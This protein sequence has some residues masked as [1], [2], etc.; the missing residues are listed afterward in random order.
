MKK[1]LFIL[2]IL[3]ILLVSSCG[4]TDKITKEVIR[5]VCPDGSTVIDADECLEE[6][7]I[8]ED[9]QETASGVEQEISIIASRIVD[10]DTFVLNTGEKVRLICVDTPETNEFY[11][12]EATDYLT[13]LILNKEIILVKDVS[14]T[15]RYG[16]LLR[17]VYLGD[18]F[19]N[20]KLVEKGYATVFRYSPDTKLC[21]ELEVLEASAKN[22]KLGIWFEEEQEADTTEGTGY[23]CNYNAYNCGNFRTHAE[24][25]A[26]YEACGGVNND[27]HQLD[28]DKDGIACES[29]P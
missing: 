4:T 3:N 23:I 12:Q 27:V 17:Y 21:D 29:L 13:N 10:G 28:K 8:I 25:Q 11:Y 24:A 9:E 18:I 7:K 1:I 5:Y 19:V 2:F 6:E 14:E 26:V 22:N 15:D 20:G 16:R